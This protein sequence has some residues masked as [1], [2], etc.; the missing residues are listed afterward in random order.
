MGTVAEMSTGR[1][2]GPWKIVVHFERREGGGLRAWCDEIPG[3]V[4]SHADVEAVLSDVQ[5]ALEG[6]LTYQL[7]QRIITTP[8]AD[9][10][11][12]LERVG[13]IDS[14]TPGFIPEQVEYVAQRVAA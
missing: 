13:V 6:L 1:S 4:L 3:F 11:A 8:L 10:R 7:G 9:I 14:V 2:S 12:E 5:P